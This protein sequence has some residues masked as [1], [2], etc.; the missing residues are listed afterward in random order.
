MWTAI[1]TYT[2]VFILGGVLGVLGLCAVQSGARTDEVLKIDR[3]KKAIRLT[4]RWYGS[5][6]TIKFPKKELREA[7]K[8]D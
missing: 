1:L 2:G 7:L 5:T 8:D 3:M 6:E 4:L